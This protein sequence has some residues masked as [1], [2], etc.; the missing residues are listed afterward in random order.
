MTPLLDTDSILPF[1]EDICKLQCTTIHHIPAKSR[2]AFALVLSATLRSVLSMNDERSWLK[3]FL[4]PKCVLSSSKCRGRH[5]KSVSIEHLCNLWSEG[6]YDALWERATHQT[7]PRDRHPKQRSAR[8]SISTAISP[9]RE[10]LYG[11]ACQALTSTGIAPNTDATWELL[12]SKHPKGTPPTALSI[13]A[14]GSNILPPDFDMLSILS[15]FPKTTACGPSGLRIQHLVDAAQVPMPLSI[16][17]S[18][19][20]IVNLL[21]SGKVPSDISKYLAGGSLTAIVKDRPDSSPDVRPIAVGEA[22]R[23]LVGKCLCRVTKAK[24]ADF[25]EPQVACPSGAEKVVHGLRNCMDEHWNTEDFVV[26]KVDMRNA[27]NLVSRQTVLDEC[28]VHLPEL[29]PWA[30][31]CYGQHPILWHTMGTISSEA[32][33]QQG[34]PLGPLLFCL[35]LQKRRWCLLSLL[36]VYAP[37]YCCMH[38]TWMMVLLLVHCWQ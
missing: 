31:W 38:G 25:F 23:R 22:L 37:S 11:K 18:L 29:L 6:R 14:L 26:F 17:S 36:T 27:F 34:D 13:E 21:A 33:V 15:S 30:S 8:Q 7:T 28:S 4:L 5:H 16:C 3:L 9:A 10:G 24:V 19:R 2:P 1:F 12:Q 35:V 32:G 20:D